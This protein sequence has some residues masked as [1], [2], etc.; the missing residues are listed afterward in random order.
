VIAEIKR[1]SKMRVF[2]VV[3]VPDLDKPGMGFSDPAPE[4][5][6]PEGWWE[7]RLH[8]H[9]LVP[10]PLRR[11]I[12][13]AN[14]R[15]LSSGAKKSKKGPRP[16]T[17]ASTEAVIVLTKEKPKDSQEALV[18]S[19]TECRACS[20]MPIVYY[21]YSPPK[22]VLKAQ[23]GVFL[24][25]VL[26]VGPGA[27]NLVRG[28]KENRAP[29]LK[30]VVGLNPFDYEIELN[31]PELG[32]SH[33]V[34]ALDRG[35]PL[36]LPFE[37]GQFD[38][39]LSMYH[40]ELLGSREEIG[41]MLAEYD[42]VSTTRVFALVNTCGTRSL[43]PQC[44]A[45]GLAGV[46]TVQHR[47]WWQTEFE[48]NGFRKE[49]MGHVFNQRPCKNAK[50][51]AVEA[52]AKAPIFGQHE[53]SKRIPMCESVFEEMRV[54][55]AHELRVQDMFMLV[56][57]GK[58]ARSARTE[59]A[60]AK[61]TD[62]P[63]NPLTAWGV[64]DEDGEVAQVDDSV[65]HGPNPVVE[66]EA[67]QSQAHGDIPEEALEPVKWHEGD[68]PGGRLSHDREASY[69]RVARE[70][71]YDLQQFQH[72]NTL[73]PTRSRPRP[74]APREEKQWHS[75]A[76]RGYNL[77]MASHPV[78]K[79]F[80]RGQVEVDPHMPPKELKGPLAGQSKIRTGVSQPRSE[81]EHDQ[82][83]AARRDAVKELLRTEA[84]AREAAAK[85]QERARQA[86][87]DVE[88]RGTDAWLSHEEFER[89]TGISL[90]KR[91]EMQRNQDKKKSDKG[92]GAFRDHEKKEYQAGDWT[93]KDFHKWSPKV[94]FQKLATQHHHKKISY[95][96]DETGAGGRWF[97]N[98]NQIKPSLHIGALE[99]EFGALNDH[100]GKK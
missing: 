17:L 26:V 15:R 20:Y 99:K 9:G 94:R 38:T 65:D 59:V 75:Y 100:K 91:M 6:Y 77:R 27:C 86:K 93:A 66:F 10:A 16:G 83:L 34:E 53:Y 54:A 22:S 4:T 85:E 55:G 95:G 37:D 76:R 81:A 11:D 13:M 92:P 88:T 82:H 25:R 7:E 47:V 42:R 57:S 62:Q 70:R 36:E 1:V 33:E 48:G 80:K 74:K 3:G 30:E 39:V 60:A 45:R 5:L 56:K 73:N 79:K 28:M 41:T 51:A 61:L 87:I 46:Q 18:A 89:H 58:R 84:D 19:R 69:S 97:N 68:V 31:C 67:I 24:G 63:V 2:L 14:Y 71:G 43:S 49:N 29:S 23:R 8:A 44:M 50:E 52:G 98:H 90:A 96:H 72:T 12:F 40:L 64:S 78:T 32:H 35:K 21:M